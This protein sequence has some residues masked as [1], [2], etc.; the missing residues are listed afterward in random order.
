MVEVRRTESLLVLLLLLLLVVVMELLLL[1]V[2]VAFV[3]FHSFLERDTQKK[4]KRE[5]L[6]REN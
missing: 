6:E 2:M 5:F 1:V 3:R 4:K